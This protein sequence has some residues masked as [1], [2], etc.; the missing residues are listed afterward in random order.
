MNYRDQFFL[1]LLVLCFIGLG[2]SSARIFAMEHVGMVKNISGDVQIQRGGVLIPAHPGV[3]L[4]NADILITRAKGA[5]GV[6]F[7]DGS[8]LAI[9]PDTQFNIKGYQFEPD[10]KAYDFSMY[11]TQGS[12]LYT[13]GKIGKLSPDSVKIST[14]RATVGVRGTRFI[15]K[16]Q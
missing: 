12:A 16:V 11:L 4:M 14:P 6:V 7:I 2:L 1:K 3:K 5:A 10:I 15:V 9:G 8:T 13:S